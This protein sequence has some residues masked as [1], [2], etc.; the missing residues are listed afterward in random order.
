M[1]GDLQLEN[2]LNEI[3]PDV[4]IV[5]EIKPISKIFRVPKIYKNNNISS[6]KERKISNLFGCKKDLFEV[7]Q[8]YGYRNEVAAFYQKFSSQTRK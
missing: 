8:Y 1:F 4:E 3:D 6:F 5:K 2:I 7:L